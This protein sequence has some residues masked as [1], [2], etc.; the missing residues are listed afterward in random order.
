MFYGRGGIL[1]SRTKGTGFSL[2]RTAAGGWS[3]PLFLDLDAFTL[4][5]TL[6][7][8]GSGAVVQRQ[9]VAHVTA[10][11]AGPRLQLPPPLPL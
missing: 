6:G 8:L 1:V 10:G 11:P 4:G 2:V 9:R 7:A 5:F 3:P